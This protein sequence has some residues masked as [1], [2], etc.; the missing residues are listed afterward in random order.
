MTN[1]TSLSEQVEGSLSKSELRFRTLVAAVNAITWSCPPSG[2]HVKPQ[3]EWMT[4]TGQTAEEMLGD[5]WTKAVHPEDVTAAAS[6]WQAAV[7]SG[8]PLTNE[9]RIRRYDGEW[10]WMITRAAPI[11]DVDGEIIEW[12]GMSIDITEHKQIE[13]ALRASERRFR[14]IFNLQFQYSVLL[15]PEGRIVELSDLI[16]RGTGVKAEEAIGELFLEG[17]WW[18][19]L[20]E[21]RARWRRQFEEAR[22][23][24][25]ASRDE[26]DYHTKDGKLRHALNTVTALHDELGEVEF[27]LAEG[28]DITER[29]QAEASLRESEERLRRVSDNADVGLIRCSRDWFFLSA[30]PAYSKIVGKPLNEIVGRPIPEVIGAE[31]AETIRPY[32]EKALRGERVTYEAE[33]PFA[34]AGQRY[35]HISYTP[36]TDADNRIFGWVASVTDITERKAAEEFLCE[37]DRRKDEFIATLAHELRNPLTPI[38]NA[39]YILESVREHHVGLHSFLSMRRIEAMRRNA[40]AFRL[41]HSQSLA[42]LR[43]RP[44]Q[45]KVRST[46]HRLG[47]T[48]KP[49]AVSERLTISVTRLGKAFFCASQK[50]GP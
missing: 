15:T 16:A 43:H 3:L 6:I 24:P 38:Q 46:T 30:N 45:E 21:M 25:G 27:F 33:V 34:G 32:V 4:F 41:R 35:L 20:P 23:Q 47:K 17:P 2:L 1:D 18:R 44:S 29:K 39:A 8:E 13:A 11:R 22:T 28:V 42:N 37:A 40:S 12:F 19:D 10:R 48:S 9:A 49:F 31:A 14:A 36:D 26:A 7:A 5:G 50:I